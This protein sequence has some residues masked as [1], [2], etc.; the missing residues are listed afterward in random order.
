MVFVHIIT[1]YSGQRIFLFSTACRPA[2]GPT[3]ANTQWVPA[4]V[5]PMVRGRVVKLI[6]QLQPV[7]RLRIVELYLHFPICPQDIV[8]N[9]TIKDRDNFTL[10]LPSYLWTP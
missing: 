3:E 7:S 10:Q 5:S 8:L 4:A 6:T 1:H 2:L 9:Y